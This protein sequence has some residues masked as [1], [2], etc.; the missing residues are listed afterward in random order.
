MYYFA[1]ACPPAHYLKDGVCVL[2]ADLLQNQPPP[3]PPPSPPKGVWVPGT[4]CGTR[5]QCFFPN[6]PVYQCSDPKPVSKDPQQCYCCAKPKDPTKTPDNAVGN[7]VGTVTNVVY[8]VSRP[9]TQIQMCKMARCRRQRPCG[10]GF[11]TIHQPAAHAC[12]C[13]TFSCKPILGY[14]DPAQPQSRPSSKKKQKLIL[15]GVSI[16]CIGILLGTTLGK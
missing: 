10:L 14:Q 16:L 12:G 6:Q 2:N 4:N 7:A 5:S 8:G 3:S 11:K 1:G 9:Q 13:S 15:I